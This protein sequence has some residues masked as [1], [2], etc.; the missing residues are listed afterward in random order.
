[1]IL[2][3]WA[4]HSGKV[5]VTKEKVLH[6]IWFEKIGLPS[7]GKAFDNVTRGTLYDYEDKIKIYVYADAGTPEIAMEYVNTIIEK[8]GF[9]N[10]PRLVEM[11]LE[12][13]CF[14]KRMM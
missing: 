13:D 14:S 4:I 1:L 10:D 7:S 12:G 3:S 9:A 2:I 6:P 11:F 5:E 8:A